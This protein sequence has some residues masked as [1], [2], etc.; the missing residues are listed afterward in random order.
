MCDDIIEKF[1]S[2]K[3]VSGPRCEEVY[4]NAYSHLRLRDSIVAIMKRNYKNPVSLKHF[5]MSLHTSVLQEM[6]IITPYFIIY[7]YKEIFGKRMLKDQVCPEQID[8]MYLECRFY[9]HL[10]KNFNNKVSQTLLPLI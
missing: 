10:D 5:V 8:S 1:I 3:Y 2:C 6:N 9:E 4:N 7:T